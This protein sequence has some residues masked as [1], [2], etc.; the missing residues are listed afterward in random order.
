[1]LETTRQRGGNPSPL[2]RH[3]PA[4]SL[5]GFFFLEANELDSKIDKA[6]PVPTSLKPVP[7]TLGCL[8]LLGRE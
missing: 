7:A 5:L 1:M 8:R 4:Y 2:I 6:M 3:T